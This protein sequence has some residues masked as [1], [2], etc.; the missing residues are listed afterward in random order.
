QTQN[1]LVG[2]EQLAAVDGIGAGVRKTTGGHVVN[3]ALFPGAAHADHAGSAAAGKVVGGAIDDGVGGVDR[4]HR[5]G[6]RA[7][8]NAVGAAGI[9]AVAQRHRIVGRSPG[10]RTDGRGPA[11]GLLA[12]CPVGAGIVRVV[13]VVVGAGTN[14][15]VVGA[16]QAIGGQVA[17]ADIV[18]TRHP[19]AG[20]RAEESVVTAAGAVCGAESDARILRAIRVPAV[21][22]GAGSGAKAHHHGTCAGGVGGVADGDRAA[23]GGHCLLANGHRVAH[24]AIGGGKLADGN[25]QVAVD[26]VVGVL[27]DRDVVEAGDVVAGELAQGKVGLAHHVVA[28]ASA[29]GHVVGAEEGTAR[30]DIV[31][32]TRADGDVV[33]AVHVA[34]G[35]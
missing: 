32:G 23:T 11:G 5:G 17:D 2:G 18:S 28:G 9:G 34:A 24:T 25:V 7:Q 31:A 22:I 27:A 20:L 10:A 14:G 21:G 1:G 12:A 33:V 15:D 29:D 13:A 19:L 3:L 6:I 4:R 30:T 35:V 8:G 16:G 26:A